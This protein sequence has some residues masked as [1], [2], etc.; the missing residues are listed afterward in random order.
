M[1]GDATTSSLVLPRHSGLF[2]GG[3]W[4]DPVTGR[5]S[6]V[7]SP[8]TGYILG[9]AADATS[10]D[11]DRAV[12]AVVAE[13]RVWRAVPPLEWAKVLRRIAAVIRD[14]AAEIAMLDAADGG[15]PVTEMT[16][17]AHVAAGMF[18]F[19]AE[20]VGKLLPPGVFGLL[21]GG[22]EVGAALASHRDV[23]M[24]TLIGSVPT[25]RAVG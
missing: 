6:P 7:E 23:A 11:A 1:N 17:D 8:A 9:Q 20:L 10:E 21:T 13:F 12:A 25:G 3:A 15:N 24:V 2:C 14:H 22:R 19:F 5:M 18:E 4:Y 16:S